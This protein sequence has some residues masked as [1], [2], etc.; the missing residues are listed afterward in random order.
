MTK[1]DIQSCIGEFGSLY[2]R[3][4][5]YVEVVLFNKNYEK[6]TCKRFLN[7]HFNSVFVNDQVISVQKYL[8]IL[9]P[10]IINAVR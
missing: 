1:Q 7:E 8:E 2:A 6:L 4:H 10:A 5:P 9:P 3:G